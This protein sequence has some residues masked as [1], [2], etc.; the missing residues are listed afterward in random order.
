MSIG[1]I[2]FLA[3]FGL[4]ILGMARW[5]GSTNTDQPGFIELTS[6][7]DR[8]TAQR[9]RD[10]LEQAKIPVSLDDHRATTRAGGKYGITRLLVAEE[11]AADATAVLRREASYVEP[12]SPPA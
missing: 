6:F 7:N 4:V 9:A 8:A 10:V 3:A 5:M 11:R 1:A 12:K 2:A